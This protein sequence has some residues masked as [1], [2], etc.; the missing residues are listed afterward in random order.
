MSRKWKKEDCAKKITQKKEQR[1]TRNWS[2][3]S[4][5]FVGI[6]KNEYFNEKCEDIEKLEATH[7]PA[8]YKKI[9]EMVPK[10]HM[11]VQSIKDKDGAYFMNQ[12]KSLNDGHN[13]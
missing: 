6:E 11:T 1:S 7:N 4:K 8:L 13:M 2:K 9:K 10:R 5:S 12:R 3:K